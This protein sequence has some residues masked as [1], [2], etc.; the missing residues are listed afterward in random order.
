VRDLFMVGASAGGIEALIEVLRRLPAALPA[1]IG[2][3]LH[4]NP[5]VESQLAAVLGR[6]SSLPVLEPQDGESARPGR[7]YLAPRDFH[8]TIEDGRWRLGRGPKLHLM[9]PAVDLLFASAARSQGRRVVGVLLSGGGADGVS[10]L[11]AIKMAGGLSLVQEPGQAR[12][13]SMPARAISEDDVDAVLGLEDIAAAVPLLAAGCA[14]NGRV[15]R[16]V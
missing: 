14:F 15:S 1:V 13:P 9:R 7:V 3:A 10:G 11:V 8:M 12:Q 2:V 5:H 16:A 4:R 6:R